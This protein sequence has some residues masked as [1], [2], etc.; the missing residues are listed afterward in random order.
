MKWRSLEETTPG[1]D[2]R[3]LREILAERKERIAKYVP[4]ATL[5]ERVK[6]ALAFLAPPHRR[7]PAPTS[8]AAQ[9]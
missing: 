9:S 1:V 6:A 2:T 3:P 5:E 4:A 7:V 8:C